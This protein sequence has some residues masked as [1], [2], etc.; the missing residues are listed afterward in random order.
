MSNI[1]Q[2][3]VD[4]SDGGHRLD[5]FLALAVPQLSRARIQQLIEQGCV[6]RNLLEGANPLRGQGR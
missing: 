3:T 6:V 1:Y 2:C 5:K 4:E